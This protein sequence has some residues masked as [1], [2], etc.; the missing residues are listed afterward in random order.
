[1]HAF[2]RSAYAITGNCV[3]GAPENHRDHWGYR[4]ADAEQAKHL[5]GMVALFPR[6]DFAEALAVEGGEPAEDLHLTLAYLGEDVTDLPKDQLIADIAS[7]AD[8]LATTLTARV[9]GHA[10][11]NPDGGPNGTSDPCAVYLIGDSNLITPLRA[12]TQNKCVSLLQ[13]P[14]QH[15]PFVPH[16]TATYAVQRLT[17]TGD[18]V[19]DRL[20]V[21]WAG[22]QYAFPLVDP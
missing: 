10:I 19:F 18:I 3:C 2:M 1:M 17:Y 12:A 6:Q 7:V 9:F 21:N 4:T 14:D 16:I 5:G 20:C 22:E 11:F 13:I 8:V 15:E